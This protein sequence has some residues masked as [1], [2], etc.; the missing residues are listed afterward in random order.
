MKADLVYRGPKAGCQQSTRLR[1][2]EAV[3]Q[4]RNI[5]SV[6]QAAVWHITWERRLRPKS[7]RSRLEI[8]A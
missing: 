3:G 2:V 5:G 6:T 7:R 8:C 1:H 4:T